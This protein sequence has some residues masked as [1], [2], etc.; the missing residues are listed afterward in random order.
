MEFK[1]IDDPPMPRRATDITLGALDRMLT[2]SLAAQWYQEIY[3]GPGKPAKPSVRRELLPSPPAVNHAIRCAQ[4]RRAHRQTFEQAEGHLQ[5]AVCKRA[6]RAELQ[7]CV[8]ISHGDDY[9]S[10]KGV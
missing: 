5:A 4:L 9:L 7:Q 8:A 10:S 6:R 3:R 2:Q 1:I